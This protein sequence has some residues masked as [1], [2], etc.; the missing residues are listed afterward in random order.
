M[1]DGLMS[2]IEQAKELIIE[3]KY[4]ECE[5]LICTAMFEHPHDAIP[6]NL[7][8]LLLEKENYHVEAMKHFSAAYA[9]DPTYQPSSWNME[10][11]RSYTMP[12][13]CAYF[14]SDCETYLDKEK[15]GGKV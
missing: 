15:K 10:C 11:F 8:G 2:L 6:H 9:L 3:K 4:K 1:E 12:H 14:A 7:M 13:S 5:V